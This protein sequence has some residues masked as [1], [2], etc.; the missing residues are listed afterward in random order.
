MSGGILGLGRRRPLAIDATPGRTSS[1][2]G[3]FLLSVRA[4][5]YEHEAYTPRD[6]SPGVDC[7]PVGCA[8]HLFIQWATT[9]ISSPSGAAPEGSRAQKDLVRP[10]PASSPSPCE[11]HSSLGT[12]RSAVSPIS[13]LFGHSGAIWQ[14]RYVCR[15]RKSNA[16]S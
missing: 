11:V 15:P 10:R 3:A 1:N 6:T 7:P 2:G 12:T 9:S 5:A 4:R 14:E 13:L 8:S 16:N